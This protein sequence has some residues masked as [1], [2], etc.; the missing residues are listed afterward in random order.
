MF[1]FVC[2]ILYSVFGLFGL[3]I[4]FI[5]MCFTVY[6][7]LVT[8]DSSVFFH[9]KTLHAELSV[10]Y[11]YRSIA[12][13]AFPYKY[14][15]RSQDC[16]A[17]IAGPHVISTPDYCNSVQRNTDKRVR[18]AY[19]SSVDTWPCFRPF[20]VSCSGYQCIVWFCIGHGRWCIC[21]KWQSSRIHHRTSLHRFFLRSHIEY[22]ALWLARLVLFLNAR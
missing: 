19:L 5:G 21:P 11:V 6:G 22:V 10:P 20:A 2:Y 14:K 12:E 8:F 3:S 7:M 18:T 4:P 1:I 17:P 16:Y 9:Q 15:I 13:Y